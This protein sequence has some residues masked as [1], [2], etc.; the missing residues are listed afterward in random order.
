MGV[1]LLFRDGDGILDEF[2]NCPDLP[3][4]EQGDADGDKKGGK[5]NSLIEIRKNN[6]AFYSLLGNNRRTTERRSLADIT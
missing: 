1:L 3:N 2:D 6:T 5:M 4:G